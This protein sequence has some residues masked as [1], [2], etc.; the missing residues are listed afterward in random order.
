MRVILEF[1]RGPRDGEILV[2]DTD[3]PTL[4]EASALYCRL[5]HDVGEDSVWVPSEY[6]VTMLQSSP[7]SRLESAIAVGCRFPGHLYQLMETHFTPNE[8]RLRL[9]HL[10]PTE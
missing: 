3:A 6:A 9:L 10:G 5:V 2:G 8:T 7:P 4:D 1:F